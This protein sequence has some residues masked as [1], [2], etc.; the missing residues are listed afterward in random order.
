MEHCRRRSVRRLDTIPRY[1]HIRFSSAAVLKMQLDASARPLLVA[2]QMLAKVDTLLRKPRHERVYEV[3]TMHLGA[4]CR[5]PDLH[6]YIEC[7]QLA[8][9]GG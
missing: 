3:R 4:I 2:R 7:I 8:H 9:I 5:T 6:M 1:E